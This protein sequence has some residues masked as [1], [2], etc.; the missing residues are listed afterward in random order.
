MANRPYRWIPTLSAYRVR[1]ARGMEVCRATRTAAGM[2]ATNARRLRSPVGANL[3]LSV[4]GTLT[5][6]PAMF[7][8]TFLTEAA[9]PRRCACCGGIVRRRQLNA[10][11]RRHLARL[12][13]RRER[14]R[15]GT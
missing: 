9:A 1:D 7:N 4:R 13:A 3:T 6:M 10:A 8:L 11:G 15:V 12:Q 14:R 2:T 5:T